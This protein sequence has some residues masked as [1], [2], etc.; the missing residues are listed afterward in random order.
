MLEL[1]GR[2]QITLPGRWP[3]ITYDFDVLPGLDNQLGRP[4]FLPKVNDGVALPLDSNNMVT[5]DTSFDLPVVGG[6]PPIRVT[7]RA[8]THVSFPPDVTDKRLSVTRIA[9]DRVPMVLEDGRA[10]NLYISVQPSGA[11]FNQPLEISFPNLDTLPA[12]TET[13][14]MSFDHDAG[15]YIKVG[16]GHVSSDGQRIVSDPGSGIRIGAW[17][18]FPPD[19]PQ[20]EVNV[21]GFI[22]VESNPAFEDK[23]IE[24]DESWVEGTRAVRTTAARPSLALAPRLAY[25]ATLSLPAN[26]RKLSLVAA[27]LQVAAPTITRVVWERI[28]STVNANPAAGGGERIF[29]DRETL[30]SAGNQRIIRVRATVNPVKAG[31]RVYFRAFDMDDPSSNNAPLDTNG[32]A[33][34]DNRSLPRAGRLSVPSALTDNNGVAT[35]QFTVGMNPGDNYRVAASATRNYLT[36]V[37]VNGTDLEDATHATLPTNDGNQT[38]MLTVWRRLHVELDSMV[39]APNAGTQKNFISG[40]VAIINGAGNTA[41]EVVVNQNLDDGSLKLDDPAPDNGRFENGSITIGAGAAAAQTIDL[42]GNGTHNVVRMAGIDVPFTLT[43][44][45]E[46]NVTGNIVVLGGLN[47]TLNITNGVLTNN[48]VG[49]SIDI[50]GVP[51]NVTATNPANSTI[52]LARHPNIP[53]ELRDDDTAPM[54]TLPDTTLMADKYEPAYIVPVVDGGGRAANN[55]Q[56]VPFKRNI[57]SD[58]SATLNTELVAANGMESDGNRRNDFWIVYIM[59]A[60]QG[61]TNNNANPLDIRGDKDPN[62]EN[63]TGGVTTSL[64]G[65]GSFNFFE[66]MT[67]EVNQGLANTFAITTAHEAAHQFGLADCIALG[68]CVAPDMMGTG[69]EQ[70]GSRFNDADLDRIRDR[71]RSPGRPPQ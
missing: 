4:L 52:T 70:A 10:T 67:D 53:F 17:H 42:E 33:G 47:V 26:T 15:R 55:K 66:E 23:V 8:G 59:Q 28:N 25:R 36:G 27:V 30:A 39:A 12:N 5:Q 35:V 43:K 14:L 1:I 11:I 19:P 13:L 64:N 44:A 32:N 49:G 71:V 6:Q 56:T 22:Q 41:T 18:A 45:G 21:T 68:T 7:A 37:T 61:R 3:N 48:H 9:T 34:N 46:A 65:K 38:N 51:V 57:A 24:S 54:P 50:A 20:E 40:L 60:F 62:V 31:T 69:F 2:D 63:A 16:T 58:N 29:P